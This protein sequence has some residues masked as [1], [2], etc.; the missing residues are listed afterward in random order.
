MIFVLIS[1]IF[2]I[3][4]II[5]IWYL[6][7]FFSNQEKNLKF[8]NYYTIITVY[9]PT[10]TNDFFLFKCKFHKEKILNEQ[11]LHKSLNNKLYVNFNFWFLNEELKYFLEHII[12]YIFLS[13]LGHEIPSPSY[14][15]DYYCYNTSY[16]LNII[17]PSLQ[18]TKKKK[19]KT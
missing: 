7:W 16:V 10:F 12:A 4:F 3:H 15:Y 5:I 1:I 8:N 14:Y 17:M 19:N 13:F 11:K 9:L 18:R 2:F 6:T